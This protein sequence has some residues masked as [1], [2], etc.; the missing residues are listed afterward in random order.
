MIGE[1]TAAAPRRLMNFRR[2]M[3]TPTAM[4]GLMHCSKTRPLFDH[5]IRA[6][7][8]QR[9]YF[10][11]ERFGGLQIDCQFVFDRSLHRQVGGLG[12]LEDQINVSSRAPVH[13]EKIRPVRDQ[14]TGSDDEACEVDRGQ[15]VPGCERNDQ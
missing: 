10:K 15:L 12:A 5:L 13:V 6:N 9:W 8:Q 7:E 11:A 3:S 14:A 2:L 1:P 4:N